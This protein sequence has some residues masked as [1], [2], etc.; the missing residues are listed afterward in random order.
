MDRVPFVCYPTFLDAVEKMPQELQGQAALAIL[1]LGIDGEKDD[2]NPYIDMML[3]LIAPNIIAAKD[4]YTA[5]VENGKKGGRPQTIDQNKVA[6]LR[7]QGNTQKQI[8][9]ELECSDRQVR[10]ILKEAEI[11]GNNLNIDIDNNNNKDNNNNIENEINYDSK[12]DY[13]LLKATTSYYEGK[14]IHFTDMEGK[15]AY[16]YE[17]SREVR[18][19]Y[20]EIREGSIIKVKSLFIENA[21]N[22]DP[23]EEYEITK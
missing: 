3:T 16:V 23:I 5:S 17:F 4:R 8:A 19:R 12:E 18:E 13:I 22:F 2:T 10:N 15:V 21:T 9:K 20:G 6:Q 1:K 11:T 7:E 14:E